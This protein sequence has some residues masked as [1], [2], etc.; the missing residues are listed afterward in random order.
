MPLGNRSDYYQPPNGHPSYALGNQGHTYGLSSWIPY[1]GTFV[2]LPQ[3][4]LIYCV[5]SSFCPS[6]GIWA[7]VR[8]NDTDWNLYRQMVKQWRRVAGCMLGD[9]YPL[10]PYSLQ[11]DQWIAWQFDRPESGDGMVQAFRREKN[12]EPAR[13]F[14][15]SGLDPAAQYEVTDLDVGTPEIINGKKLTEQG[16]AVEIKTKPGAVVITYKKLK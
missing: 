5:R 13:M 8:R 6:F 7:D 15:L 3:K 1:Q 4:N 10:T 16:L 11:Y 14:R 2:T 12:E 9:Y